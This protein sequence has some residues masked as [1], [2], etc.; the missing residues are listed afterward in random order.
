[1]AWCS[2]CEL[3]PTGCR[4]EL[5][6]LCAPHPLPCHCFLT[7]PAASFS[8]LGSRCHDPLGWPLAG[9]HAPPA[10]PCCA[11]P[12]APLPPPP[13]HCPGRLK[14]QIRQKELPSC[15]LSYWDI[16]FLSQKEILLG[17]RLV[18]SGGGS[19]PET[20]TA[21]GLTTSVVWSLTAPMH[22]GEEGQLS[23]RPC[24]AVLCCVRLAT[25]APGK[26]LLTVL[27]SGQEV[28]WARRPHATRSPW[29]AAPRVWGCPGLHCSS[30]SQTLHVW[31][32]PQPFWCL[33]TA[34]KYHAPVP[35]VFEGTAGILGNVA[36]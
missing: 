36:C 14:T 18:P 8:S 20:R 21:L 25:L 28:S 34:G 12:E 19:Q 24:A 3:P 5:P 22:W 6:A 16:F 31:S 33:H 7:A 11:G 30:Q 10:A 26:D 1:M 9:I 27:S 23:D 2:P 13:P 32:S 15:G 29:K 4:A 35:V 17:H